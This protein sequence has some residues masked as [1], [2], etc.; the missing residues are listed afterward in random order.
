MFYAEAPTLPEVPV[1]LHSV[2]GLRRNHNLKGST[3]NVKNNEKTIPRTSSNKVSMDGP[4]IL[5]TIR[6]MPLGDMWNDAELWSVYEYIRG[7]KHLRI[8]MAYRSV[9][10]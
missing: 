1:L 8:P 3:Y 2:F 4:N 7:S 6:D 9:L 5:E 10:L